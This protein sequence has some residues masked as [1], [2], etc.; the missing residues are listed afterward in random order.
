MA[1]PPFPLPVASLTIEVVTSGARTMSPYSF[2]QTAYDFMGGMWAA[3]LDLATLDARRRSTFLRWIASLDGPVTPFEL[4]AVDY[5]GPF[6]VLTANP[7]IAAVAQA[8][9]QTVTVTLA[10]GDE[11][12]P[13]DMVTI[14]GH[15]HV[16]KAAAAKVGDDQVITI[17][18]RLRDPVA[19]SDPVEALAPYGR[20]ALVNPRNGYGFNVDQ[21]STVTLDLIE[22]I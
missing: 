10:T 12:V 16:I 7:T 13:D 17:W 14:G 8:R 2:S 9:A 1:L 19:I 22:A 5:A 11:L 21:R 6:G 18:P 4:P 20:W 3:K 15:L